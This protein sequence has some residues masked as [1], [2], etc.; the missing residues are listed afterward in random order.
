MADQ[1][2]AREPSQKPQENGPMKFDL[3]LDEKEVENDQR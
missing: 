3:S 2:K 1:D